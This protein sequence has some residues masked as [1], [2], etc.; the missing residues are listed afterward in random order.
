MVTVENA[1]RGWRLSLTVLF[2]GIL[3]PIFGMTALARAEDGGGHGG[4]PDPTIVY[5]L[6][7]TMPADGSSV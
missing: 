4:S 6:I 1:K 2:A 7:V 3:L 5:G